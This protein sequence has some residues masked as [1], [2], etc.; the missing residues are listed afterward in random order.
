MTFSPWNCSWF[1]CKMMVTQDAGRGSGLG[2]DGEFGWDTYMWGAP[3]PRWQCLVLT[4]CAGLWM[5]I[6]TRTMDLVVFGPQ[7]E[8]KPK[9]G[10]KG[11]INNH[12]LYFTEEMET[13]NLLVTD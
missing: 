5:G 8:L 10:V 3:I 2:E 4:G 6:W 13:S 9:L 11:G 1:V 7:A 12:Y